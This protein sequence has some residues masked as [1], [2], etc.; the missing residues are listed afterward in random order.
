MEGWLKKAGILIQD[1][2]ASL[3]ENEA[4]VTLDDARMSE[5][6]QA[7]SML[8]TKLEEYLAYSES[9][10]GSGKTA[11]VARMN[12]EIIQ[13][14]KQL[15]ASANDLQEFKSQWNAFETEAAEAATLFARCAADHSAPASLQEAQEKLINVKVNSFCL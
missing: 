12:A 6:I 4:S 11:E 13:L 2:N 14:S 15:T 3:L 1:A 9:L 8:N 10:Q 7:L 5:R